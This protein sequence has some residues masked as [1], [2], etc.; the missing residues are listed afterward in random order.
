ML[1]RRPALWD[2]QASGPPPPPPPGDPPLVPPGFEQRVI[3][4]S[5]LNLRPT[6]TTIG[7]TP[8]ACLSPGTVLEPLGDTATDVTGRD[9]MQVRVGGLEGWV[10]TEFVVLVPIAP[11]LVDGRATYYHP[12][13]AGNPMFCGGM[14]DPNN[15]TIAASTTHPCGTQLRL[16]RDGRSI[17]VIVQDTGLLPLNH[18]DLS[19][20]AYNQLGLPAEGIIPI[21]IEVLSRPH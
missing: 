15:P 9:W 7:T 4:P 5:C 1:L 19:E 17:R 14:Y 20:A 13:L 3:G 6:P 21:Q 12:S 18:I 16:W 8:L 10:A 2:P 11:G